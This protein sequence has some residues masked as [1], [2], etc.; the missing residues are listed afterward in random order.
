MK[1]PS[2]RTGQYAN[3]TQLAMCCKVASSCKS[4]SYAEGNQLEFMPL[5]VQ[6]ASMGQLSLTLVISQ[7]DG[8]AAKQRCTAILEFQIANRQPQPLLMQGETALVTLAIP[9]NSVPA[10]YHRP[11][12]PP[13]HS[14]V[15]GWCHSPHT[16]GCPA[17]PCGHR[18]PS[19]MAVL[20]LHSHGADCSIQPSAIFRGSTRGSA[21]PACNLGPSR[22]CNSS[23]AQQHTRRTA[24]DHSHGCCCSGLFQNSR[25]G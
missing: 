3:M 22:G 12:C 19:H 17:P 6:P 9:S 8:S 14:H 25:S 1:P 23:H 20:P 5:N 24:A 21:G 16:P 18:Q 13:L 15:V 7:V 10:S 4:G 2:V 11:L